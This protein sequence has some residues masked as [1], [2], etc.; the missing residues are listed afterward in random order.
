LN[1]LPLLAGVV[2]I[3]LLYSIILDCQVQIELSFCNLLDI[4]GLSSVQHLSAF[5]DL[6]PLVTIAVGGIEDNAN[7][8]SRFCLKGFHSVYFLWLLK[9]RVSVFYR[10]SL[11]AAAVRP[12]VG[13]N[14]FS[15]GK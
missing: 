10:G 15:L 2:V 6:R 3:L 8:A 13:G 7:S 5:H 11:H 14:A 12:I 4:P 9:K 1:S